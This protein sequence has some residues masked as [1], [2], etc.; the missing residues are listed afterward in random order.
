M[1]T[2][3][4]KAHRCLC[5]V[6]CGDCRAGTFAGEAVSDFSPSCY[7][8]GVQGCPLEPCGASSVSVTPI[9]SAIACVSATIS[10]RQQLNIRRHRLLFHVSSPFFLPMSPTLT[11]SLPQLC[12]MLSVRHLRVISFIYYHLSIVTLCRTIAA[13]TSHILCLLK[14][15][16]LTRFRGLGNDSDYPVLALQIA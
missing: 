13:I 1:C 9:H 6:F 11:V 10:F 7:H 12:L 14:L 16:N 5:K 15:C 4:I 2:S 3:C 8:K